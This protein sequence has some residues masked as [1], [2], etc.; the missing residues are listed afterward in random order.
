MKKDVINILIVEDYDDD[1]ELLK[2]HI[3]KAGIKFSYRLV[4]TRKELINSLHEFKPDLIL[5]DYSMPAFN[6]MQALML[7]KEIAPLT[8]FI[9]VTNTLNED[10]AVECMKA[11]ADDYV[12]KQNLTRLVPAIEAAI[13]KQ[14]MVLQKIEA[15]KALI[16][17]EKTLR[18][19]FQT[20]NEGVCFCR[21]VY[22]NDGLPDNYKIVSV[23]RQFENIVHIPESQIINKLGSEMMNNPIPFK[24]K[25]YKRMIAESNSM[26][27]DTFNEQLGKHLLISV[28]AWESDGFAAIITDITAIRRA[29]DILKNKNS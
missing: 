14:E 18:T 22:N 5:S 10:I 15:E 16:E 24:I 20:M 4:Q 21:L 23:N 8:P 29:E 11:G 6:G 28:C 27:M 12:I 3:A 1:A 19:L 26:L 17:S 25:E 2:R 7:S 9:L 13:Q